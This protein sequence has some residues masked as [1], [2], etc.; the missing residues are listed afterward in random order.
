LAVTDPVAVSVN[1]HVLALF[2]PLEQAP[3]Q[4][5]SRPFETLSVIAVPPANDADPLLPTGTL[6]P[7]GLEVMRSPLRPV[8]V[9]VKVAVCPAG[10]TVSVAVRATLPAL[11]VIVTGVDAVTPVVVIANVALADPCATVTFA[12]I[13]AAP[14]LSANVTT[15]PPAGAAAVNVTVP[16]DGLPPATEAGLTETADSAA[17]VAVLCGVKLRVDDH[18]PAVPAELKPRTRHQCCRAASDVAVNCDTATV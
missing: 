7:D 9:S 17:G 12:G 2:P 10:V 4:I 16:C 15:N 6:I 8:A 5:A 1:V 13:L 14:L 11:A 3:D 18:A